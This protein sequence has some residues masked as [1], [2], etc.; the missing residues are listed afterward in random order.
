MFRSDQIGGC[1]IFKNIYVSLLESLQCLKE[2]W[3]KLSTAGDC[4]DL[5]WS[6]VLA[7]LSQM[8]IGDSV[9]SESG[10]RDLLNLGKKQENIK[11]GKTGFSKNKTESPLL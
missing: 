4:L 6:V 2:I 5:Y 7:R 11:S 3:Q 1:L 10:A 8:L 9:L